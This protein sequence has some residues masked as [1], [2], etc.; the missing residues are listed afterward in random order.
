MQLFSAG[1]EMRPTGPAPLGVETRL[2]CLPLSFRSK[3]LLGAAQHC[4]VPVTQLTLVTAPVPDGSESADQA[5]PPSSEV[6]TTPSPLGFVP[7]AVQWVSV[8]HETEETVPSEEGICET[9]LVPPGPITRIAD[10]RST[11]Q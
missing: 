5:N 6:S 2:H 1:Q 7:T 3:P 10:P 4:V 9:A 11:Q 8:E